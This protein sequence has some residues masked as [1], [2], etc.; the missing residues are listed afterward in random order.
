MGISGGVDRKR[1]CDAAGRVRAGLGRM[2][3]RARD[4]WLAFIVNV[5]PIF[6]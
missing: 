3:T 4:A 2:F 5:G 1:G 6:N